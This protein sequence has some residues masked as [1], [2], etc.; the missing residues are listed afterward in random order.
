MPKKLFSWSFSRYNVYSK[1]PAQ[2]KYKF[3]DKLGEPGSP[4]LDHGSEVHDQIDEFIIGKLKRLCDSARPSI[5]TIKMARKLYK[6][7]VT[8]EPGCT[9]AFKKDWSKTTW[10]DWFGCW[11]RIKVDHAAVVDGRLIIKDWK[12]GAYRP[13]NVNEYM[14]QLE[15]Y[16]VGGFLTYPDVQE[17]E[18]S[19]EYVEHG[20]QYPEIPMVYKRKQ[21][22]LLQ[23]KW[24]NKSR[25]MLKDT[26]YKATPHSLC[27]FCHFRKDNGGPCAY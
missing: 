12:T 18:V 26:V 5:D 3:I 27:R 9:W 20:T 4:A 24:E 7:G 2:A 22:K 17:V 10:D 15:L 14:E 19:L 6:K 16:V 8:A 23:A 13:Y 25:A 1:C 21:L 11:L